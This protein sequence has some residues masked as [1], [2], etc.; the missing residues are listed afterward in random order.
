MMMMRRW[1]CAKE[2]WASVYLLQLLSLE[3]RTLLPTPIAIGMLGVVQLWPGGG[4]GGGGGGQVVCQLT[5]GVI[6]NTQSRPQCVVMQRRSRRRAIN[7]SG[8]QKSFTEGGSLELRKRMKLGKVYVEPKPRL[9][10]GC[11]AGLSLGAAVAVSE[12][13]EESLQRNWL[14]PVQVLCLSLS[15]MGVWNSVFTW[16]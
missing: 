6:C 12:P 10:C 16:S 1:C 4:G 11:K 8:V 3:R 5:E 2:D 13:K 9:G 14:T 15:R 7:G